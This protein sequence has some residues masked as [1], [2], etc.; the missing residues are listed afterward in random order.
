LLELAVAFTPDITAPELGLAAPAPAGVLL[1]F[2]GIEYA[3]L[4]ATLKA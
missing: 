3:V 2:A 1:L 4:F